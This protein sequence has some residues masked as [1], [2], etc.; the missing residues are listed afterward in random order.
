MEGEIYML[1]LEKISRKQ[2]CKEL[3]GKRVGMVGFRHIEALERD[4][5]VLRTNQQWTFNKPSKVRI[6]HT[7]KSGNFRRIS[8]IDNNKSYFAWSKGDCAY[9]FGTFY[10]IVTE[11]RAIY[12]KAV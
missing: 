8:D 5:D 9:K 7:T 6:F 4:L 12:Y 1:Q 10:I 3:E 11:T 2:F